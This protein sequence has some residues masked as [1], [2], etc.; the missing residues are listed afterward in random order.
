MPFP[1]FPDRVQS[2]KV[3]FIVNKIKTIKHKLSIAFQTDMHNNNNNNNNNNTC[4]LLVPGDII[5]PVVSV[6]CGLLVPGD[7]IRPVVNVSH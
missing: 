6:T 4:G 3:L 2:S 7:I 1:Y 5:R